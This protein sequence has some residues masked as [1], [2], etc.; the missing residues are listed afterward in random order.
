MPGLSAHAATDVGRVRERNEDSLLLLPSHAVYVVADGMGGH[1]SGDV[2]SQT[3]ISA[4]KSFFEDEDLT[5]TLRQEYRE[6][7]RTA[8]GR[9][10]FHAFEQ[11]CLYRALE[12]ANTSIFN[13]ARRI[14]RYKDMGTTIVST[15]FVRN[16]I[17]VGFVGDSRLYR[18]RGGRIAQLTEDHSLANEYIRMNILKKEDLPHFPY[19]NVIVRALGLNDTARIDTFHRECRPG[20]LYLLCTD[21]LTDLVTDD[22]IMEVIDGAPDLGEACERLVDRANA[23]GGVDNITV[24]LVRVDEGLAA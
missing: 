22:E 1:A 5:A 10:P 15:L 17:Y 23:Y 3:S 8:E 9:L 2:A 6:L 11:Y 20:D 12:S 16:R 4:I 7:R 24:L 18:I 13:T 21:G 19:K 14:P